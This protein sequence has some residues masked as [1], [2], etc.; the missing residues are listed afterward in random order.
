M[1]D[2]VDVAAGHAGTIR[3]WW[4]ARGNAI[5]NDNSVRTRMGQSPSNQ[6]AGR[7]HPTTSK[8]QDP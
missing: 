6:T 5:G 3:P 1:Q 4:L 2:A 8:E 7:S